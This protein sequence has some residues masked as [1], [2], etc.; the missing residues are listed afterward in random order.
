MR[1]HTLTAREK[2]D[3][4]HAEL[5]LMKAP[6]KIGL[7]GCRSLFDELQANH[8]IQALATHGVG[9]FLPYHRNL[10]HAHEYF[11]QTECGYIGAQP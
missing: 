5:C 4:L 3:Y 1:R 2:T 11:L 10:M 9:A 7:P 6:V 8:Q